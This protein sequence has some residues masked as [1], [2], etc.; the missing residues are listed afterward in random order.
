MNGE[1]LVIDASIAVKWLIEED[2]TPR[3][4]ALR[5]R[6]KLIAPDLLVG[7]CANIFWKKV[8]RGELS[9]EEALLAA[10]I[11]QAAEIELAPT[12]SLLESA[13]RL[14][15]ELGQPA[16]DCIYLALAVDRRCRF[17]TGDQ[18]LL[19]KLREEHQGR[20][21]ARAVSLAEAAESDRA[22]ERTP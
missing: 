11:L 2:G 13:A 12:R 21:H 9:Q 20:F 7:E 5:K 14:A 16:Y 3:A 6:A 22:E 4:L 17:A 15:I 1:T 19:R 10:R 18:R 8:Q